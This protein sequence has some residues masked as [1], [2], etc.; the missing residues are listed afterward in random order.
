MLYD[1]GLRNN[2]WGKVIS[3]AVHLKNRSFTKLSKGITPYEADN[4]RNSD[5]SNLYRF[6]WIVYHHDENSQK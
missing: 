1:V 2:Q 6:G 3:T 4:G 5:L